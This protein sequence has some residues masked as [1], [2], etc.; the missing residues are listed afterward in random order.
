[1]QVDQVFGRHPDGLTAD[2]HAILAGVDSIE[3]ARLIDDDVQPGDAP[4]AMAFSSD[5]TRHSGIG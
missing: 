5:T 1:M 2:R 3:H 4:L